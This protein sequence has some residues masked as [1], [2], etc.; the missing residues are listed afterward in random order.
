MITKFKSLLVAITVFFLCACSE[1]GRREFPTLIESGVTFES[2]DVLLISGE[3]DTIVA[4]FEPN[5]APQRDYTW[6]VDDPA[7]A[8]IKINEDKSASVTA[9]GS[10]ETII[11]ITSNDA[12]KLTAEARL[13][14]IAGAP[15]DVTSMAAITANRE[16]SGG[17]EAS[18]GS[19]KLIDGDL[20]SKYLSDYRQPFYMD[21][22][23]E[24]Q[25][26]I[27]FYRLTSG[28]DAPDRDPL[29][30][31][32]L[33]SNDGENWETLDSRN[34]EQFDSRNLTREFYFD[35]DNSYFYYRLDVISNNGGGLFQMSEWALLSIPE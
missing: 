15:V 30:W 18:E 6:T 12:D 13:K 9:T 24:E 11:R 1:D 23:F 35:N 31:E 26:T 33:G 3:T 32:I 17:P 4:K 10:G 14:V 27:N 28:N 8:D 19:L 7:I 2:T 34:G 29:D 22:K 25:Q 21:L 16:N 5:I 20:N